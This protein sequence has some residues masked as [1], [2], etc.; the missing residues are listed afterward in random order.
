ML[1]HEPLMPEAAE[2]HVV[3]SSRIKTLLR[4]LWM[5]VA[6]YAFLVALESMGSAFRLLN[7]DIAQEIISV[8]ANPFVSLFIGLLSTAILQSSSTITAMVVAIVAS[9]TISLENAVPII[10]GA[11]IGTTVTSTIVSMAHIIREKEFRKAFAAAT[12]HDIF[13][14][15]TAVIL[16]PLEYY[17][18]LLSH[19]ATDI[20]HLFNTSGGKNID[21]AFDVLSVTVSPL[22]HWLG[23]AMVGY[24]LLLV[25]VSVL[26]LFFSLQQLSMVMKEVIIG[27]SR[28]R[29]DRYVFGS[30][31]KALLWGTGLTAAIQSSSIITSLTVPLV[32][33]GKVSLKRAFPFI[34]GANIG[35]TFTAVLAAL[36]RSEAA[37]S[38]AF[39]HVLFNVLGVMIFFPFPFTREIPLRLAQRLS[40]A[41]ARTR[42]VSFIYLICVFFLIPFLLIYSVEE[43]SVGNAQRKEKKQTVLPQ[44]ANPTATADAH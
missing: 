37:L 28:R 39:A 15:L 19:L 35:T 40:L 23:E 11:N 42:S 38:I 17:F 9:G 12:I 24:P 21:L 27:K 3:L 7:S 5:A 6:L 30:D 33:T 8:M 2:D 29:F 34:M 44:D 43:P 36:P 26:L 41:N 25:F 1:S 14:I 18:G 20:T 22:A 31:F 10:M 32:G 16:F 13:N 4:L